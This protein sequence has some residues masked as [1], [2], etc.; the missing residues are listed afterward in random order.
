MGTSMSRN[1]EENS[2]KGLEGTVIG[3][4]TNRHANLKSASGDDNFT[5]ILTHIK[6]SK[7][8]VSTVPNPKFPTTSYLL[9]HLTIL[10][11]NCLQAV[12]NYGASWYVTFYFFFFLICV[13]VPIVFS[14]FE[15]EHQVFDVGTQ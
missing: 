14:S 7:S 2:K 15:N 5:D 1:E 4:P 3:S 11:C 12:I 9:F 8:P 10:S 13:Y 6:S